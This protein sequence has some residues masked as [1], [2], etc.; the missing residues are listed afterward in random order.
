MKVLRLHGS[1]DLRLH[2]ETI[3]LA[4]SGEKLLAVKAVGI[5]GSDLH[6]FTEAGIGDAQLKAPLV[7]G[8]EFA[9]ITEID[10]RVAVD[11]AI[12][13]GKCELCLSG[14]TNL[15]ELVVFS[16]HGTQDGALRE[17]MPWGEKNFFKLPDHLSFADGAMLE[18]LGVAIHAVE[19]AHLKSGMRVGI[20][21][22][23]TIGLL[24][25]Q[26]VKLSGAQTI[27]ATEKLEHRLQAAQAHGATQ[28]IKAKSGS[29]IPEVMAAADQRGVDVAFEVAGDQEAV[30]TAFYTTYPG[31]K[32]ILAGIPVDDRT[33]FQASIARRKGLTI[34]MVRRMKDTY[35]KAIELVSSGKV[36]VR[37]LVTHRFPIENA[38][39]AFKVAQR[40]EGIKVIIEL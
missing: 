20:F 36:D 11:P 24:I 14:N 34:K 17:W 19:L 25:I 8:H 3:P 15:C 31:G 21:G 27:I 28:C 37:S 39:E 18:P 6:W 7:L 1:K 9:G 26:L 32:V 23:G 2:D 38:A 5:C 29:E 12:P 10:Q 40:R 35:P 33:T 4:G 16:G 30:D 22:C 13:C